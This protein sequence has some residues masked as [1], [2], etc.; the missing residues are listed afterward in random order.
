MKI[1][2]TYN[3]VEDE[4]NHASSLIMIFIDKVTTK[5]PVLSK[6]NP[7]R[8]SVRSV[9]FGVIEVQIFLSEP[10]MNKVVH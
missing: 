9:S 1:L 4:N 6:V 7:R 8:V 10:W 5:V 3:C 2:F